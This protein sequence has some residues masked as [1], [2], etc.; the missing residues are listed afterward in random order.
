M[1]MNN[2]PKMPK[3][4]IMPSGGGKIKAAAKTPKPGSKPPKRPDGRGC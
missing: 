1:L 4:K 3:K 2:P